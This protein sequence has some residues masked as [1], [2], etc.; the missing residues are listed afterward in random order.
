MNWDLIVN[1]IIA[2][3]AILNP[4]GIIPVWTEL[5]SDKSH[6]IRIRIAFLTTLTAAIILITFLISG[7]SLLRLFH[8]DLPAFRVAGGALLFITGLKMIEG[9]ATRLDQREEEGENPLFVAKQ[10]FRKIIVPLT[11]PMLAGPGSITTVI[12]YGTRAQGVADYAGL[13]VIVLLTLVILFSFFS[14]AD[15]LERR[16]DSMVFTVFTRIFGLIIAAIAAQF[17]L[18][19]LGEVYP[20][21]LQGGSELNMS[22][23]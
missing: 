7:E 5:T 13:S 22:E 19:A 16:L 18:E 1:F 9:Q 3:I 23:G 15:Y 11:V 20:L 14:T 17:V 10:R 6:A 4:M 21:L 12:M 2:M 8:I